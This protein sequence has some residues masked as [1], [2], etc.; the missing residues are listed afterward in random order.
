MEAKRKGVNNSKMF[1]CSVSCTLRLKIAS[2]SPAPIFSFPLC[3]SLSGQKCVSLYNP[4]IVGREGIFKY[5]CG[6]SIVSYRY[7]FNYCKGEKT[8]KF[9]YDVGVDFIQIIQPKEN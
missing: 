4:V 8:Q 1:T 3:D 5:V 6:E 9:K 2:Q 7:I